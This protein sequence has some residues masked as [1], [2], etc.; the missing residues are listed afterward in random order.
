[1]C[2]PSAEAAYADWRSAQPAQGFT[3]D[4]VGGESDGY[5]SGNSAHY[6]ADSSEDSDIIEEWQRQSFRQD[7]EQNQQS[8]RQEEEPANANEP[9]AT[10]DPAQ[11]AEQNR[12]H[13]EADRE[14]QEESELLNASITTIHVARGETA[15]HAEVLPPLSPLL[16]VE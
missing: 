2:C 9:A 15:H 3:P 1:M 13:D 14:E 12:R 8:F 16:S 10:M 6:H 11:I 4:T 7:E 5:Q